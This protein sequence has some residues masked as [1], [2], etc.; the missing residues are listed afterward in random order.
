MRAVI[1]CRVSTRE[2]V[3]NYSLPTQEKECRA[4]CHRTGIEVDKVFVE[5]GESAKTTDRPQFQAMLEYCRVNKRT[6]QYLV[7]Y[8][9]SRFA[10]NSYDH[11]ATKSLLAK[12]GISLRSVT[13]PFDDSS[14]GKFSEQISAAY[15]QLDNDIRSER[16]MAGMKAAVADGKFPHKAPL[17]YLNVKA[18]GKEPNIVL[19]GESADF[20][21]RAFEMLGHTA[22]SVSQVLRDLNDSGFRTKAGKPVSPQ[23]F[24]KLV[25]NPIYKGEI[26]LPEWGTRTPGTFVPIVTE[27]LFERVQLKISG[28]KVMADTRSRLNP[29]FPLRV[30]VVCG[31]CGTGLTGSFATKKNGRKYGYYW[32]RNSACR[33]VKLPKDRLER[34]YTA[35][36]ERIQFKPEY[37]RLFVEVVKDVWGRQAELVHDQTRQGQRRV[38]NFK[39]RK[40]QIFDAYMDRR[41]THDIYEEQLDRVTKELALAEMSLH[42]SQLEGF[43]IDTILAFAE[44]ALGNT[45]RLWLESNVDQKQM[46]QRV[47]FPEGLSYLGGGGFGTPASSSLFNV[48]DSFLPA[49][50]RLASPTGFEPVLSP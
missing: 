19:D 41:I 44:H 36:L 37:Q 48:L 38:E 8:Q 27:E 43:E 22:S 30:F 50:S 25:R 14:M 11:L 9:V 7:V 40:N 39:T 46:L 2:Q 13:E 35:F 47:L 12:Y 26:Y 31:H 1:Y 29:D 42:D 28:K 49:E 17:G 15:A 21:R 5:E 18:I 32:C 4:F 24:N 6:L 10:R 16:T 33:K 45:A 3:Q 20:V 23:T 34:D